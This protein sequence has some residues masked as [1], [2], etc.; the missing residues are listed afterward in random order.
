MNDHYDDTKCC[1][2]GKQLTENPVPYSWDDHGFCSIGCAV[3]SDC[4]LDIYGPHAIDLAQYPGSRVFGRNGGPGFEKELVKSWLRNATQN[5]PYRI[6]R[7]RD[8]ESRVG[9]YEESWNWRLW[10]GGECTASRLTAR[11]K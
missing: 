4:P 6:A 11:A 5:A 9:G 10:A 2:C 1:G 8:H 3:Q 7:L